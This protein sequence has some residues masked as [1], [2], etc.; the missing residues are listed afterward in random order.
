MKSFYSLQC[1]VILTGWSLP[2]SGCAPGS[3]VLSGMNEDF[4]DS[5]GC[6]ASDDAET[7]NNVKAQTSLKICSGSRRVGGGAG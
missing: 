4:E 5:E 7:V 3:E 1:V 6:E 2:G